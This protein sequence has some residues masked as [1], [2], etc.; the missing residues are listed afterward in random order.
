MDC[1]EILISNLYGI[2]CVIINNFYAQSSGIL[3]LT[4]QRDCANYSS[5]CKC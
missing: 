4:S 1:F 5:V 2:T 3:V